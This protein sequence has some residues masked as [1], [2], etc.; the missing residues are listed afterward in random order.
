MIHGVRNIHMLAGGAALLLAGCGS[1][2]QSFSEVTGDLRIRGSVAASALEP[3]QRVL[4]LNLASVQN[5]RPIDAVDVEVKPEAS[6]AIHAVR[7][8]RGAYKASFADTGHVQVLIITRD[9]MAVIALQ[10]Q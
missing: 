6:R 7:E 1:A 5:G 9:R 4:S 3:E 10:R 8:H 2:A